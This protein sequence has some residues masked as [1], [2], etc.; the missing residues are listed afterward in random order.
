MKIYRIFWSD[1]QEGACLAWASSKD[2]AHRKI[3]ELRKEWY[4]DLPRS[5]HPEFD[6]E[7]HDFDTSVRGVVAWLN[8]NLSRNN[9]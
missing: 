4:G 7:Y 9:G 1:P 8:A 3:M 6:V 5:D 2:E